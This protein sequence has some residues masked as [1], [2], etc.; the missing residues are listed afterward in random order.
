[1]L[2]LLTAV[3]ADRPVRRSALTLDRRAMVRAAALGFSLLG[4]PGMIENQA[5][6][7]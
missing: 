5:L 7:W 3:P 1:V 2:T 6:A 4:M